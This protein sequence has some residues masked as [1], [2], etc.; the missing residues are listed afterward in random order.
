MNIQSWFP[1]G[2]TGLI[3][4]HSKELSRVFSSTTVWKHQFFTA[5]PSLL[6]NSHFQYMTNGKTIALTIQAF[7]GKV[8]TLLCNILSGFVIAFLPR[9]KHPLISWLQSLSTVILSSVQF[10]R[11]VVSS[12]LWPHGPQHA[13][14]LYPSSTPG[15]YSNSCPLSWWCH[16]TISSSSPSPPTLNLSQHQG[17]FQW[18]SCSH[19][20]AKVLEFQLQHQSFQWIFRTDFL[21]GGLV[22]CPCCR[23][24]RVFP[25]TTVQKNQFFGT[26]LSF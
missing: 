22:G 2:L 14:P 21:R 11:S 24:L 5:R 18:V 12:S 4:L 26:Q 7:V 13:R 23:L 10:S 16:P 25:N 9:S 20:V 15:V 8:M 19:Q 1:L 3:S 6:S 17:L